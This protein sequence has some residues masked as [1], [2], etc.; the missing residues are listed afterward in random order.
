[1]STSTRSPLLFCCPVHTKNKQTQQNKNIISVCIPRCKC[2]PYIFISCC[3]RVGEPEWW[4]NEASV[5]LYQSISLLL[6]LTED[7]RGNSW[8]F[9]YF[10]SSIR[11]SSWEVIRQPQTE[12]QMNAC[13][14][15]TALDTVWWVFCLGYLKT[16]RV[17]LFLFIFPVW[18][19]SVSAHQ[20]VCQTPSFRPFHG[21][22]FNKILRL[23]C[24]FL[25]LI[26]YN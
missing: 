25:K 18:N 8:F 7:T 4:L 12:M 23:N 17:S 19:G 5:N 24:T 13:H 11:L 22:E 2:L 6:C 16:P 20:P 10:F 15:E 1:M 9:I 14:S 21:K 26:Y 3:W